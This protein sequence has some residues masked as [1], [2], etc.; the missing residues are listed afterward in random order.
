MGEDRNGPLYIRG[1]CPSLYLRG[2]FKGPRWRQFFSRVSTMAFEF[3]SELQRPPS[4]TFS[5]LL[6]ARACS[7][8]EAVLF[9]AGPLL[10]GS[11]DDTPTNNLTGD[12]LGQAGVRRW[13][14]CWH[15]KPHA[16]GQG[17]SCAGVSG[18]ERSHRGQKNTDIYFPAYGRSFLN[19]GRVFT[20]RPVVPPLW[21]N[22]GGFK[23]RWILEFFCSYT[24][25][26]CAR[27]WR[28]IKTS[29][30]FR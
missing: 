4:A 29:P 25:P 16:I 10:P 6:P 3:P 12:H 5:D 22:P 28:Q 18:A 20:S 13:C 26:A 19:T 24:E 14:W 1:Q 27:S 7:C 21:L 23:K 2:Q 11:R 8:S 30:G 15:P 9:L 17:P